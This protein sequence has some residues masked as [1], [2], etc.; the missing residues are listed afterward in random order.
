MRQGKIN[1]F[2][3]AKKEIYCKNS[4]SPFLFAVVPDCTVRRY[5]LIIKVSNASLLSERTEEIV[6]TASSPSRSIVR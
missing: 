4:I 3:K 5:F 6:M 1:R 2:T